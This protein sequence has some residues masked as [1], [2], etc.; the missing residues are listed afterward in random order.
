LTRESSAEHVDRLDVTSSELSD[1]G[2]AGN[3]WPVLGE[4]ALT[5]GILLA[6]PRGVHPS[7]LEAK[8][9]STDPGEE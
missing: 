8:V 7:P 2:I 5:E 6:E 1:I 9:K 4:D 3:A